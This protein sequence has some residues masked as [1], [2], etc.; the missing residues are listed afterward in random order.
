MLI[1]TETHRKIPDRPHGQESTKNTKRDDEPCRTQTL[2]PPAPRLVQ[3]ATALRG[4]SANPPQRSTRA[5]RKIAERDLI[6]NAGLPLANYGKELRKIL[7][8]L[9]ERQDRQNEDLLLR[10]HDLEYR[11]EDLECGRYPDDDGGP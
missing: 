5:R 1:G 3:R 4:L 9:A 10:I 7:C 6:E 11:I 2:R 8:S